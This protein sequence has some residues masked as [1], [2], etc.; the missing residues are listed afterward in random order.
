[1]SIAYLNYITY[2]QTILSALVAVFSL[3][4]FKHRKPITK[5]VGLA[6]ALGFIAN[7]LSLVMY[8][9]GYGR[10]TNVPQSLYEL[11]NFSIVC[12]IYHL[13]LNKVYAKLISI[14]FIAF[15]SFAVYNFAL[16]QKATSLNTYTYSLG[17]ILILILAILYFYR[18]MVELPA[19]H[20]HHLP[21]FWFNA[22]FLFYRAGSIILFA[23]T[24]YL[25]NVMK[26]DMITFW[27]FHNSLNVLAHCL[28]LI[29]L[30]YEI[31]S[32][33]INRKV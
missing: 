18:L 31:K 19:L 12:L 26:D 30:K 1:M 28:V 14:M 24:A 16:G 6:F 25:V 10:Y 32:L 11:A 2:T 8:Y 29:G 9:Q 15:I 27:F 3:L 21:M 13:A 17:S 22:A 4:Y 33:H 23:C 20:V 5:L 7:T